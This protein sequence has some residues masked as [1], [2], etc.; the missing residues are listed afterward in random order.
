[1]GYLAAPLYG[2]RMHASQMTRDVGRMRRDVRDA[3]SAIE[4]ACA[5]ARERGLAVG[6]LEREAIRKGLFQGA[7]NDAWSGR[8]RSALVRWRL[9]ARARPDALRSR[10]PW[11]VLARLLL[12]ERPVRAL[13]AGWRRA[14][15][16][17][18]AP[19]SA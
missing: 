4:V 16:R 12:G 6:E 3:I 14:R 17:K 8:R 7:A 5:R 10:Y 19:T 2:Y 9:A 11:L 18:P 13:R 1:M 15:G